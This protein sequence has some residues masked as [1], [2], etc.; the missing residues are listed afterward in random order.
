MEWLNGLEA[1]IAE[2]PLLSV[3]VGSLVV[4]VLLLVVAGAAGAPIP[5]LW[6]G[7]RNGWDETRP[8]WES[9]VPPGMEIRTLGADAG[10]F[11][12]GRR[13]V[14]PEA[15][16][17]PAT[18]YERVP[19]LMRSLSATPGRNPTE[20]R[21][22][23]PMPTV[24]PAKK[25]CC[26]ACDGSRCDSPRPSA[27]MMTS[28]E[29]RTTMARSA[30]GSVAAHRAQ[31]PPRPNPRR[32]P[33]QEVQMHMHTTSLVDDAAA[34]AFRDGVQ[35]VAAEL[36][37]AAF[38][39]RQADPAPADEPKSVVSGGGGQFGGGGAEGSWAEP[40][41]AQAAAPAP[42]PDPEPAAGSDAS[43]SPD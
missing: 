30:A 5:R 11:L 9:E 13:V 40:E 24:A 28:N 42:A 43:G 41:R 23:P 7:R 17:M 2:S 32:P 18:F 6:P 8:I 31:V 16:P 10:P 33:Q 19:P 35:D 38:K 4:F 39:P 15:P 34:D 12:A 37:R 1:V 21:R 14:M 20:P 25:D 27:S 36:S 26:G 22:M 29:L 3:M